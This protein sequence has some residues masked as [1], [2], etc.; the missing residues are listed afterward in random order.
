M[1]WWRGFG[2]VSVV[3]WILLWH[4][5]AGTE[6]MVGARRFEEGAIEAGERDRAMRWLLGEGVRSEG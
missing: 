5:E 3:W 4:S 2:G 6:L 1:L